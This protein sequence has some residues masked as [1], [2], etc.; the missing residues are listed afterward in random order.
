[1]K[2]GMLF[3][4][5]GSQ[6]VGMGKEFYDESRIVQEYF[7]EAA[8]CLPINFVK[9]C[10]ASSDVEL[11][12]M[13]NA[14]A[15]LFL[16]SSS[17][18][19]VMKEQGIKPDFVAGYDTGMFAALFAANGLS[20]PDGLYLLNK[21]AGFYKEMLDASHTPFA[22]VRLIGCPTENIEILVRE[23]TTR[24]SYARIAFYESPQQHIITGHED[25]VS[26]INQCILEGRECKSNDVGIE[27]GLHSSFMDP[28]VDQLKPYLEKVDFKDLSMP[29]YTS[30]D[31]VPITQA[32]AV[33]DHVL[34]Y[35]STPELVTRI[36]EHMVDTV[37]VI[38]EVGP[39]SVLCALIKER[40]P[41]KACIAINKQ[42][43]IATLKTMLSQNELTKTDETENN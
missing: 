42:E 32:Q 2:I 1:M 35:M 37:D 29:L 27:R 6:F 19:A 31:V 12:H 22:G 40:Y 8:N 14:Y 28:V 17:L 4:G 39:G 13:N 21:Y 43:D 38:I 18:Y 10:F 7:E 16:V 15:A 11:S 20:L 34:R 25:A 41:D 23:A 30:N 3:P 33:K 9:L 5:Y 24:N 36:I 26:N